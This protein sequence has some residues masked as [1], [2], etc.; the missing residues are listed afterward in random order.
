[1]YENFFANR[2]YLMKTY[3]KDADGNII[4]SD[5]PEQQ[6]DLSF[7]K[8]QI[9]EHD[10]NYAE[11]NITDYEVVTRNDYL[12]QLTEQEKH[13]MMN[14]DFN[15]MMSKY[16]GIEAAY[17]VSSL[18]FEVCYFINLLLQ[19]RD[20]MNK[21]WCT[22]M[23]ALGG[24]CTAYTMI[25]FLLASLSKRSGFD[26]NIIYEPQHIAEILRFNYGDIQEELQAIID[27][28]ELQVDV[29]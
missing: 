10:L 19:S 18:T 5:D 1:S 11:E 21:I 20:N 12:W 22:N 3:Q 26:G 17:D 16:I 23:Y 25:I 24:K 13:D 7:I 27:K 6:Y 9:E 28:Y 4:F 29:P 14:E 2:Y 15:I 8:A